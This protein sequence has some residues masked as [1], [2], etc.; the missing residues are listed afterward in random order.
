ML[1]DPSSVDCNQ[2]LCTAACRLVNVKIGKPAPMEDGSLYDPVR[3]A[4]TTFPRLKT[5]FA[6]DPNSRP[7]SRH[8][9]R[10]ERSKDEQRLRQKATNVLNRFVV[11]L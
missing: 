6:G 1:A 7:T 5:F 3:E 2:N 11:Q 10:L 9:P 8:L 4:A